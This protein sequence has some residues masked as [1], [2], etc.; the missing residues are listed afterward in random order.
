MVWQSA[1]PPTDLAPGGTLD[2][3]RFQAA[4]SA[5]PASYRVR[6]FGADGH[7]AGHGVGVTQAPAPP[8]APRT[9][10]P[11]G[12]A[13]KCI[14]SLR[15]LLSGWAPGYYLAMAATGIHRIIS[16]RIIS[17]KEHHATHRLLPSLLTASPHRADRGHFSPALLT[18]TASKL[19]AFSTKRL[20][21]LAGVCRTHAARARSRPRPG[22]PSG[23]FE[24]AEQPPWPDNRAGRHFVHRRGRR[25][26]QLGD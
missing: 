19:L 6:H 25:R 17:T 11:L 9:P 12:A 5:G 15:I 24:R 1:G 20:A 4:A 8:A 23:H 2:D 7:A 13:P 26:R 18:M 10:V 3:F 16:E 22:H 14:V 21:L